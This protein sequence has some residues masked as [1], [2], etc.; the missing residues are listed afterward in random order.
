LMIA[1]VN[2]LGMYG[3]GLVASGG[4]QLEVMGSRARL[5]VRPLTRQSRDQKRRLRSLS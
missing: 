1:H 3:L 5:A 4:V 2:F